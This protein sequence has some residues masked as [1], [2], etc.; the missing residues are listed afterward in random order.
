MKTISAYIVT[1]IVMSFF[2]KGTL[3]QNVEE[4]LE[5]NVEIIEQVL[6]EDIIEIE[7]EISY[8]GHTEIILE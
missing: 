6:N 1:G 5:Y 4:Y 7:K 8:H 2:L 3:K